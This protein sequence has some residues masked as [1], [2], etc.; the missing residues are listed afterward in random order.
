[1]TDVSVY[2][3]KNDNLYSPKKN[4]KND[5]NNNMRKNV[6]FNEFITSSSEPNQNKKKTKNV[7]LNLNNNYKPSPENNNENNVNTN[8]LKENHI[9][10][11]NKLSEKRLPLMILDVLNQKKK[12]Q[13]EKENNM[14]EVKNQE[15]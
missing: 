12:E 1:M 8:I 6:H 14:N 5:G 9:N 4:N 11:G 7:T 15:Y 2:P 3:K 13:E 10:S